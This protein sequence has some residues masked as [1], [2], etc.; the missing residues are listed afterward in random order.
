MLAKW[1]IT[2]DEWGVASIMCSNDALKKV[3]FVMG[4][5]GARVLWVI[6]LAKAEGVEAELARGGGRHDERE[7]GA[8]ALGDAGGEQRR[9]GDAS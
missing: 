7:A 3:S 8:H 6:E 9:R 5:L 4:N 2:V 1:R